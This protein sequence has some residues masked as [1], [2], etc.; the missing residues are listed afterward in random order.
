V[1]GEAPGDWSVL[2]TDLHMPGVDG[3][4]LARFAA[5]LSPPIPV[6]LVTAR[7]DVLDEASRRT[8]A[9]ILAKPVSGAQLVE[10]V[11]RAVDERPVAGDPP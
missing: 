8:F 1:L 2:V 10:A 5:S 7:P 6:V 11:R 9:A 4:A 3:V